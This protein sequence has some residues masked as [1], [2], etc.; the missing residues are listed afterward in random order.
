MTGLNILMSFH[1]IIEVGIVCS[2]DV[3]LNY[4][5]TFNLDIDI[6][7]QRFDSNT[8]PCWFWISKCLSQR[9][10]RPESYLLINFIHVRKVLHI[11]KEDIDLDDRLDARS[12]CVEHGT[13]VRETLFLPSVHAGQGCYSMS[14]DV[15][16]DQVS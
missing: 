14:F 5:N 4:S 16:V 8:T 3:L 6:F 11:G 9:P 10:L 2:E 7:R 13:Q 12:R 15:S 1:I